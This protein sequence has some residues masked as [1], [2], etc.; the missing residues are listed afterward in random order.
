MRSGDGLPAAVAGR[1]DI[2]RLL[3]WCSVTPNPDW[4]SAMQHVLT[5][6]ARALALSRKPT[7]RDDNGRPHSPEELALGWT[8]IKR[9]GRHE[10]FD[11]GKIRLAL[12]RCF[13]NGVGQTAEE[14][15]PLVDRLAV[16]V[17]NFLDALGNTAPTV[18]QVQDAV[19][20][21]LWSDGRNEAARHYTIYREE[22]RKARESRPI[23]AELIRLIA[24]DAA[25]FPTD[26]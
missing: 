20:T 5:D 24:E 22:R 23:P 8:I 13:V 3:I 17:V 1:T 14:V 7:R 10:D 16:R 26:L 19:I 9:D 12:T 25:H 2:D 11:V 4:R 15:K 6:T 18:E 21:Q